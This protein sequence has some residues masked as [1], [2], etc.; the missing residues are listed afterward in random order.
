MLRFVSLLPLLLGLLITRP[1]CGQSSDSNASASGA[2]P[3]TDDT[4]LLLYKG[5]TPPHPGIDV[6]HYAFDLNLMDGNDGIRGVATIRLRATTDTLSAVRL[7]LIQKRSRL[8][9]K[10]TSVTEDGTSVAATQAHHHV[11]ITPSTPLKAGEERTYVVRYEGI[12]EDGLIIQRNRHGDRT[13]FGDNWPNRARHWL[14]VVDHLADKATVEWTVTAPRNVRIVA[15]GELVSETTTDTSRTA[16]WKTDVPL[17]PKVAVIGVAPFAIDRVATVDGVPVESWV[18]PQDRT[19]GFEDLGQAPPILRFFEERLGP[20]P[21]DKLANVQSTTRYGGMENASSIFYSEEAVSDGRDST[22]LLAHEIAHQWFGNT[23]TEAD[24]PHLWLSEGFA[25][26]LTGLYL[27]HAR[28]SRVFQRY[29]ADAR[30][31]AIRF[32][33]RSPTEALVDTTYSDPV[34]LLNANPYQRGAWVLHMLRTKVGTETLWEGLRTYYDRFRNQNATTSDFRRVMEEVSGHDLTTFFE[35][36]VHRPGHPDVLATWTHDADAAT[37]T[38]TLEQQQ[39]GPAYVLPIEIQTNDTVTTVEMTERTHLA[40]LPCPTA[41]PVLTLDP[42]VR[43]LM[44][45]DVTRG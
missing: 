22:P 36:W 33:R 26:Y 18:Y 31:D 8:G 5:P 7:D 20:Y 30:D 10:V 45:S 32:A 1:A 2:P 12:P 44:T 39:D 19:V 25:T 17:P 21:Y 37:C 9:M 38:V 11:R 34:E 23:V 13:F 35:Q 6:Q 41:P 27:E 16:H 3:D 14:P 28:G 43:L 24:W 40:E 4:A 15:N 29:M 42:N